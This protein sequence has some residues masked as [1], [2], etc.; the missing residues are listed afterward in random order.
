MVSWIQVKDIMPGGA[1]FPNVISEPISDGSRTAIR[2][3]AF[4]PLDNQI[5]RCVFVIRA[6]D[7]RDATVA[8]WR[9]VLDRKIGSQQRVEFAAL[10]P[11]ESHWSIHT[12]EVVGAG[13][14]DFAGNAPQAAP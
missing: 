6:F 2:I 12:W 13:G 9:V 4:N 7:E 8:Q 1:M 10:T 3:T 5:N 11:V 14:L